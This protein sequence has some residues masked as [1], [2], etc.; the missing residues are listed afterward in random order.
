MRKPSVSSPSSARNSSGIVPGRD[1]A[2]TIV[3]P[4]LARCLLRVLKER[5]YALAPFCRGLGFQYSDLFSDGLRL[6]YK[7]TR[8]LITRVLRR[9]ND[10]EIGIASGSC[11]SPLSWGSVGLGLLTCGTLGEA[12]QLALRYQVEAGAVVAYQMSQ[13]TRTV[14][15]EVTPILPDPEIERFLI[16]HSL[17]SALTIGRFLTDQAYAP[18]RVELSFPGN[19][20]ES[21]LVKFFGCPVFFNQQHSR[22][23][24][25]IDWLKYRL[26]GYDPFASEALQKNLVALYPPKNGSHRLIESLTE[27][28]SLNLGRDA[29]QAD[30]AATVNMSER[31][32]R[33]RL[34]SLG[35]TF[36]SL[37]G[38][39]SYERAVELLLQTKWSICQISEALGYSSSRAFRRAFHRWAGMSPTE[40]RKGRSSAGSAD[41]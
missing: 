24:F 1:D 26:R 16:E 15:C 5:G 30:L 36:R 13:T 17:A 35:T 3:T 37:E 10:P 38:K 11:Q 33:R 20:H 9:T 29:R 31:T 28:I 40:F 7:Q 27:Q 8:G 19:G 4:T 23:V 21:A 25:D 22:M 12:V 6:S 14:S 32:M 2:D 39:V 18:L 34:R 41:S